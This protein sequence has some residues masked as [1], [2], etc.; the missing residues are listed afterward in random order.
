MTGLGLTAAAFVFYV[1]AYIKSGSAVIYPLYLFPAAVILAVAAFSF[2]LCRVNRERFLKNFIKLSNAGCVFILLFATPLAVRMGF[3]EPHNFL[4][5]KL[6]ILL[7]A[8]YALFLF[9]LAGM[10]LLRVFKA[11]S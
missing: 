10:F 4:Q 6:E 3:P 11:V 8:S 1:F 7:G 2:L 9:A 5:R